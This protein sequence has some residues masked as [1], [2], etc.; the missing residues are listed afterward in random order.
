MR[1]SISFLLGLTLLFALGIQIRRNLATYEANAAKIAQLQPE[2]DKLQT[3]LGLPD[4]DVDR[5]LSRLPQEI[6]ILETISQKVIDTQEHAYDLYCVIEPKGQ[7]T[8]SFRR[9]KKRRSGP[10]R[11]VKVWVPESRPVW[12]NFGIHDQKN[13][14]RVV[15]DSKQLMKDSPL[16]KTGPMQL[17]LKPGEHII[18]FSVEDK[19]GTNR[20]NQLTFPRCALKLDG[21][22]LLETEF[23]DHRFSCDDCLSNPYAS[24]S[25]RQQDFPPKSK[26]KWLFAVRFDH[27]KEAQK[28]PRY[29]A[30]VW[31]SDQPLPNALEFPGNE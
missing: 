30:K 24:I 8:L 21:E 14:T 15:P 5:E 28:F 25:Y 16:S 19:Q 4:T 22:L 20:Q 3:E 12:L 29:I 1:F 2:I 18:E 31:L 9:R 17:H 27:S 26:L 6:E 13:S 7:D 23:E 11:L 10:W